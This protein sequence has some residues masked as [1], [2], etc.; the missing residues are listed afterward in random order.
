MARHV[1]LYEAKTHLSRLVD[2]A[3]NGETI[4]IAKSGKPMARLGPMTGGRKMPR[5]LGQ[6]A[7][8]SRNVDWDEWWRN[9]KTA[10]RE[11]EAEFEAAAA[12]PLPSTRVKGRRRPR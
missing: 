10:D 12:K 6:L 1:S 4:V 2:E 5:R 8:R 9:W 7:R 11:I 3:A